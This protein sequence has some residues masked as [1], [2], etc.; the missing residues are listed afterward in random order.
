MIS[1]F[2]AAISIFLFLRKKYFPSLMIFF[3]LFLDGFQIIPLDILTAGSFSGATLDSALFVF[4]GLFLL[5][6]RVWLKHP[7]MQASFAKLVMVFIGLVILNLIYGLVVMDYSFADV[8][9]GGR[10]YFFLLSFLMFTEIPLQIIYKLIKT[11]IFITF[12][13]SILFSLQIVTGHSILQGPKELEVE[14]LNYVRFYNGPKLVDFSMLI[15]L[16]WNPFTKIKWLRWAMIFVFACNIVG[17][18]DRGYL[19]A[20]FAAI[21]LSAVIYNRFDRKVFYILGIVIVGF[22]VLSISVVQKR[23]NE[24]IE[25]LSALETIS[26]GHTILDD[27]TFTYRIQHLAERIDYIS[28][29]PVG[30]L[31]GI[32]LVDERA[33][34]V[35]HLPFHWGLADPSTGRITKVYTAD[36][37]WSMLFLTLG[38]V[39]TFL[40]ALIFI[41]ILLKF[42][43]NSFIPEISKV[44]FTLIVLTFITS[45][46]SSGLIQP[47]YYVPL[48]V[49][50]VFI[51]KYQMQ[52]TNKKKTA[53]IQPH[54]TTP[55]L[56]YNSNL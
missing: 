48:F 42:K 41:W 43:K 46:T 13:Q 49:L 29:E 31:F 3:F 28:T 12:I 4:I 10:L 51:C 54:D 33:P 8:F 32:G 50:I 37:A 21:G 11:L 26:S 47:S 55:N 1:L 19:F 24:A 20:W 34:Q 45:I 22:A 44:I 56:N 2:L 7:I 38:F 52:Q 40:Y 39:G 6:G 16:F 14:D 30:W 25:N 18:L 9:K 53:S 17:P 5:R 27:N 15:V 35:D 23:V 36:I